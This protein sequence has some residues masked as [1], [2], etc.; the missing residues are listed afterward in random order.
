M[1]AF[2]PFADDGPRTEEEVLEIT[3]MTSDQITSI[4]NTGHRQRSLD[5]H[6]QHPFPQPDRHPGQWGGTH[7]RPAGNGY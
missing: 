7:K 3:G 4:T 1:V 6:S 2:D 5:Y